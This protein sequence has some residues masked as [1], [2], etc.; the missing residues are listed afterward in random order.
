MWTAGLT[1]LLDA[2][3]EARAQGLRGEK[4]F[5]YVRS[6]TTLHPVMNERQIRRCLESAENARRIYGDQPRPIRSQ[7]PPVPPP[8]S[9][10]TLPAGAIRFGE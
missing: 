5:D 9:S 3:P 8:E 10:V 6:H 7:N 2:N 4:R 1:K